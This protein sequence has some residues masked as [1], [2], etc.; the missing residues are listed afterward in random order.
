MSLRLF[1]LALLPLLA[2][3]DPGATKAPEQLEAVDAVFPDEPDAGLYE[4]ALA[5]EGG[6]QDFALTLSEPGG[7]A[8][9]FQVHS[10]GAFDLA[11]L[12]GEGRAVHLLGGGLFDRHSVV[13]ADEA[14]PLWVADLGDRADAV[15][16]VIGG[17]P[18]RAG[19][20]VASERDQTWDWS[21]TTLV[22]QTDEGEIELLPGEVETVTIGGVV[23]RFVAVAAYQRTPLPDAELTDC[24]VMEDMVA[25]E[26][27]RVATVEA[28]TFVERPEGLGP[29]ELGCGS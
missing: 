3:C 18:V 25:Y 23:W 27:L 10:P 6:A 19:A 17:R 16:V 29:A 4:G 1:P 26:M 2:A 13:V 12:A 7:E 15:S 11:Q 20:E 24:P 8:L 14:G 5:V 22:V 9:S 21:Y 28:P